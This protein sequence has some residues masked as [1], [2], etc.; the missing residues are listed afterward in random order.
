[1]EGA[2]FAGLVFVAPFLGNVYNGADEQAGGKRMHYLD[3]AA[4]TSVLPEVVEHVAD[5]LEKNYA[6]PSSLYAPGMASQQVIEEARATLAA[7]LG[8]T[9]AEVVFT[10]SGTEASNIALFGLAHSRKNWAKHLVTTGYEHPAVE[11][12]IETLAVYEGFSATIVPPE[13]EGTIDVEKVLAEVRK[14]TALVSV[15]HVNNE[16]GAVVDVAAL[17]DAVKKINPRTAVHVDGVQGFTK[18]PISLAGTQIDS[19]A[20]SGHKIHA[21]K[22][23]GALYLRKGVNIQPP[24]VGGGQEHNLRPGTENIAYIAG[25]ALAARLAGERHSQLYATINAL[26]AQLLSGLEKLQEVQMN[27]PAGAYPGI[28]NISLAGVR[29][30]TML[31]FLEEYGV[32][33]SSGSACHKGLPSHTLA[34]MR[35]PAARIDGA[36]RISFDGY[37][38]PGDI[39]ALLAGLTEGMQRLVKT[40][41]PRR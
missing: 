25:L 24:L 26:R 28:V 34:A 13:A 4:T 39:D 3:N 27:S 29:S 38:T 40:G 11:K 2:Y 17:A 7:A 14:D 8:C 31:H 32:Y 23:V 1:M 35:L 37:N 20:L 41:A 18:L 9:A 33:V 5:V 6:N 16:T 36:L 30:E 12:P 21:P 10:G 22:G 15:M 19:Y